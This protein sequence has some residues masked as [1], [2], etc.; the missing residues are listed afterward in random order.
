MSSDHNPRE[1]ATLALL[2]AA[3]PCG[4]VCPSEETLAEYIDGV[5]DSAANQQIKAH[6]SNCPDCY[7]LW[8]EVVDVT[9]SVENEQLVPPQTSGA[10]KPSILTSLLQPLKEKL[11]GFYF[12]V[13][14]TA[15]S[16]VFAVVLL[17]PV[18]QS[19][20]NPLD[21]LSASLSQQLPDSPIA[22]EHLPLPWENASLA[23][24][25]SRPTPAQR[26]LGAG[27]WQ[28]QF[29][30]GVTSG[31]DT[32]NPFPPT[33]VCCWEQTQW[34]EYYDLGRWLG[35]IWWHTKQNHFV[36]Q[37]RVNKQDSDSFWQEQHQYYA[38]LKSHITGNNQNQN[39]LTNSTLDAL[40]N[41]LQT[42]VN[43]QLLEKDVLKTI[44]LLG[45]T[46]L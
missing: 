46:S 29:E 42:P 45:P 10:T 17:F 34:Q 23:F 41:R 12:P 39:A 18:S 38:I 15:L 44:H 20:Q 40:S 27:L 32:D 26:A 21:Q 11:S 22:N 19:T 33:E 1:Q 5:L 3:E 2:A 31:S 8:R 28:S 6:I 37:D 16:V 4:S 14:M 30:L 35:L 24:Q 9:E 36:Q 25:Q 13:T 7:N 43:Q